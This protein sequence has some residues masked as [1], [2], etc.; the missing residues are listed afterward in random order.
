MTRN[1]KLRCITATVYILVLLAFFALK[2]FFAIKFGR[3]YGALWFD[4]LI[5]F[6]SVCGA[7]EMTRAFG[8]KLQLSQK[9][10]VI[11]FSALIILTYAISDFIFA[12]IF[13]VGGV[14]VDQ[15]GRNYSMHY[16]FIALFLGIAI[17]FSLMVFQHEKVS[18]ESA[19][20]SLLSY[21]YPSVFLL[22]LTICN[23]LVEHSAVALV[24]VFV[25]SPCADTLA[26]CFGKLFGKKLPAKMAPTISPNKTVIG[27][28]GGL[29]G[30]LLGGAIVFF[31][32]YGVAIPMEGIFRGD[33]WAVSYNW[34]M[35]LFF[36]A[37]GILVSAFAQ[38]GDLVES[39]IKR[40]LGIKDMG[41]ILPGHG[42]ILDRIDSSLYAS[43][44]VAL[45]FVA[46]IM[47][48]G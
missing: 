13:E 26:F 11:A 14:G 15:Q 23:H 4:A 29:V 46:K 48:T 41:K 25:I 28:F 5:V 21:L 35:L 7:V 9:I 39:A 2:E 16:T 44:I 33:A 12:E 27:G 17:L 18:I 37:V 43:L 20:Y 47:I 36:C 3:L 45:V 19:G 6:F 30:G 10:V 38:F 40:D 34:Y 8:E 42:G 31:F 32:Y 22:A 1:T 24:M